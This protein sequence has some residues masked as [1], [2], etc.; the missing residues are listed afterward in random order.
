MRTW[1]VIVHVVIDVR[2]SLFSAVGRELGF[3]YVL[4]VQPYINKQV[5]DSTITFC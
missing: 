1:V 5:S 3:K 2:K 4:W